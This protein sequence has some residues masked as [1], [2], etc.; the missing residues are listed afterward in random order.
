MG[1]IHNNYFK[2]DDRNH[3]W[4][5][6]Q[7]TAGSALEAIVMANLADE[8]AMEKATKA[9]G[10]TQDSLGQ[11]YLTKGTYTSVDRLTGEKVTGP[12]VINVPIPV[13]LTAGLSRAAQRRQVAQ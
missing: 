4:T 5:L 8:A 1:I 6:E 12:N 13:A 9:A 10:F 7:R 11:W 3:E 2:T